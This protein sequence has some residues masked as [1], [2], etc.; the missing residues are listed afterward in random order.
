MPTKDE[1]REN[2]EQNNRK[3]DEMNRVLKQQIHL[4]DQTKA[5]LDALQSAFDKYQ[6]DVEQLVDESVRVIAREMVALARMESPV[7]A[8][9]YVDSA[10]AAFPAYPEDDT[11][12]LSRVN[13]NQQVIMDLGGEPT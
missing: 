10:L 11:V 6:R 12:D 3:F 2:L 1:L 9:G 13:P 7:Y 4:H 8:L 5:E